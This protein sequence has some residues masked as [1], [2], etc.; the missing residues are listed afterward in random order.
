MDRSA[1]AAAFLLV[2]PVVALRAGA[3]SEKADAASARAEYF[4]AGSDGSRFL[5]ADLRFAD[6]LATPELGAALPPALAAI[7][8]FSEQLKKAGISLA[9]LPVPPKA[10]VQGDALG[11][12]AEEGQKMRAGWNNIISGLASRGVQAI[13]L[14]PDYTSAK[15]PAFCLRDTHW[16]GLGIDLAVARIVP[17]MQAVGI[18][19]DSTAGNSPAWKDVTIQ[20]D[21]GGEPEKVK[22]RVHQ[23]VAPKGPP[24]SVLLLGDSHVLV[25]HQGG[26]MHTT[27]AGLAEQLSF[28]LG[29]APEV[30]GVRGSGATSSRLQLHRRIRSSPDYLSGKK[31]VVWVFAGREF[32][33][34]DMWKKVPV[35]PRG[36]NP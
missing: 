12:S 2:L 33:E 16:S 22:L 36:G 7:A 15:E 14:L 28:V 1:L 10:L 20:G 29:S 26:E 25:F 31:L 5:P 24:T 32:T 30:L 8:D 19:A 34:A 18:A 23:G 4:V 9:V 6:K 11:I 35:F 13:D 27:G 21:L 17:A 3:L